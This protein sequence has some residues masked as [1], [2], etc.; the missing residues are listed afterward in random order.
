MLNNCKM[1]L[2]VKNTLKLTKLKIVIFF[3][4]EEVCSPPKID[5]TLPNN[6]MAHF[7]FGA[8]CGR[9][10]IVSWV[11]MVSSEKCDS[12]QKK[13]PKA[14]YGLQLNLSNI[15]MMCI[16][17]PLTNLSFYCIIRICE[18]MKILPHYTYLIYTV[19]RALKN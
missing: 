8:A 9:V 1:I 6:L 17:Q 14:F 12:W 18:K 11:L 19:L 15:N 5:S 3:S 2:H 7:C 4:F 10:S 13:M 16:W